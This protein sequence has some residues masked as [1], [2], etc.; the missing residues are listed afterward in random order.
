MAYKVLLEQKTR[1]S[2]CIALQKMNLFS[3]P[4]KHVCV[5]CHCKGEGHQRIPF[6]HVLEPQKRMEILFSV[7]SI[8]C[9]L[10]QVPEF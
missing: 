3:L 10:E 6:N 1:A 8:Y 9:S 4:V 2:V 7:I 5:P